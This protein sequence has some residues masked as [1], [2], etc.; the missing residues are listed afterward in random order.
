[1][2]S[3]KLPIYYRDSLCMYLNFEEI[4]SNALKLTFE[5]QN[6]SLV[7]LVIKEIY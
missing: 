1:M 4:L 3:S 5:Q 2:Y 7:F 6:I